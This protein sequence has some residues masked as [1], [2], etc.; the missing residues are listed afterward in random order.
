M[1][2]STTVRRHLDEHVLLTIRAII[3]DTVARSWKGTR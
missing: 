2:A 1:T 3:F